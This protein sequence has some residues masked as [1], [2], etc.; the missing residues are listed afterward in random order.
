MAENRSGIRYG[1]IGEDQSTSS[2][3]SHTD[4][5]MKDASMVQ[6]GISKGNINISDQ[7][8][9]VMDLSENTLKAQEEH[10]ELLRRV[11]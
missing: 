6:Q 9:E 4:T 5:S 2:T 3:T 10:A 11:S 7:N 8:A 1:V